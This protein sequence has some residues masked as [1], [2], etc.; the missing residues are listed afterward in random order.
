MSFGW[1]RYD[2]RLI[3]SWPL[4]LQARTVV[5]Y[6]QLEGGPFVDAGTTGSH[7]TARPQLAWRYSYGLTAAL[8][9]PGILLGM[10]L[11][12]NEQGRFR[13]GLRASGEF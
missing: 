9:L 1:L 12:W 13:P 4:S 3:Y 10:D 8:P 2:A 6:G 5:V 7:G 11:A